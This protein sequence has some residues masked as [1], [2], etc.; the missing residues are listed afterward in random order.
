MRRRCSW[1]SRSVP[2]LPSAFSTSV[3]TPCTSM[4]SARGS[5]SGRRVRVD[6][7][8]AWRHVKAGGIDL[9]RGLLPG[10]AADTGNVPAH[11]PDVGGLA[12]RA[13]VPSMTVPPRMMTS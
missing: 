7:D 10:Q 12:A 11:D 5:P 6:V 8:E 2:P 13:P 4:F 9:G 1:A 3:V